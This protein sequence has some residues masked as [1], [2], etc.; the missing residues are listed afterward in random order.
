MKKYQYTGE[1]TGFI[2][3]IGNVEPGAVIEARNDEHETLL[4]GHELFKLDH[5]PK[6]KE[7]DA[8]EADAKGGKK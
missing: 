6:K 5:T 8:P 3:G 7:D 2:P 1:A 4:K